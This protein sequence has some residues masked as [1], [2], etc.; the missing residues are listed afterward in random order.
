MCA[1]LRRQRGISPPKVVFQKSSKNCFSCT[2]SA[3][4]ILQH[5]NANLFFASLQFREVILPNVRM[6]GQHLLSPF[7][8]SSQLADSLPYTLADVVWHLFSVEL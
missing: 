3:S 5:S 1:W 6:V 7:A 4:A 2:S 8:F